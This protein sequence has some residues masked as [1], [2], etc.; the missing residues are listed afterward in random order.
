[1]RKMT[2]NDGNSVYLKAVLANLI[3]QVVFSIVFSVVALMLN[4]A[5]PS[6]E[7]PSTLNIVVMILIQAAFLVAILTTV[8]KSRVELPFVKKQKISVVGTLLAVA[9]AVVLIC[10]F[11]WLAE[12]FAILL[13]AIGYKS[14]GIEFNGALDW[15]LGILAVVVIAPI[16]EET[17]FRSAL[18]GGLKTRYGNAVSVILCGLC[19]ALMHMSAEQTVYQ[20]ILGCVC[21]IVAISSGSYVYSIIIHATSN[22]IALF[23]PYVPLVTPK[24]GNVSVLLEN[25][26][27]SI[28]VTI[29]LALVGVAL[30]WF[31]AKAYLRKRAQDAVVEKQE[32]SEKKGLLGGNMTLVIGIVV[33]AVMWVSNALVALV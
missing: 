31:I 14:S 3:V 11:S 2:L 30:I 24:D 8:G 21:A 28:P 5:S 18:L 26:A 16:I 32:Q 20:F 19:F 7:I 4:P 25:V 15:V 9:T 6:T 27:L 29:A 33:C 13:H 1:M 10:C 22:L 23:L 17:V 12:W